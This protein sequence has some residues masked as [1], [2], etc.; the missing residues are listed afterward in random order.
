MRMP[1]VLHNSLTPMHGGKQTEGITNHNS[2]SKMLFFFFLITG[3]APQYKES[4]GFSTKVG[5]WDVRIL[6]YFG[7]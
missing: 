7:Q 1:K 5:S 4:T 3:E 6:D 2:C